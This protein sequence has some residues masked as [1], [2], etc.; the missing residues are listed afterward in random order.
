VSRTI[1]RFFCAERAAEIVL[2]FNSKDGQLMRTKMVS[3]TLSEEMTK[4]KFTKEMHRRLA[5][6]E[7]G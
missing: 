5:S 2:R 7:S 3:T 4:A 1:G 6:R